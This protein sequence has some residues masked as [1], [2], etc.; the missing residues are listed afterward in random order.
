MTSVREIWE[1]VHVRGYLAGLAGLVAP[2]I[3]GQVYVLKV[4]VVVAM[5]HCSKICTMHA[6]YLSL[7]DRDILSSV[8][9]SIYVG[10]R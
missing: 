10:M 7:K 4:D 9:V 3:T 1:K 8:A 5:F 2:T 6:L